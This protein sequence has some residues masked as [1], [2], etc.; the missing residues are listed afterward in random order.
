MDQNGGNFGLL[1]WQGVLSTSL[2]IC[3][4]NDLEHGHCLEQIV[5]IWSNGHG[6]TRGFQVLDNLGNFLL[7]WRR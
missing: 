6:R 4:M 3:N 1:F 2:Q 7:R 5:D